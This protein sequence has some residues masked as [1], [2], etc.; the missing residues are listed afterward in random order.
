MGLGEARKSVE[1][2]TSVIISVAIV[3]V[4]VPAYSNDSVQ[5]H[6]EVC[7]GNGD[8]NPLGFAYG[9]YP[10]ATIRSEGILGS[11]GHVGVIV[12]DQMDN[13]ATVTAIPSNNATSLGFYTCTEVPLLPTSP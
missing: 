12:F 1:I 7:I 11:T 9:R 13:S 5:P 2:R 8:V 10:D 3:L 6:F 4:S